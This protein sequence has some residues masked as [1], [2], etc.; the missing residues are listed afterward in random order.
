[1]KIMN[2][3][4][5]IHN[6]NM[7][8]FYV[9]IGSLGAC[10]GSFINM[11]A[12]RIPKILYFNWFVECYNFLEL[13]PKFSN[14]PKFNLNLF[15][16]RSHCPNCKKSI[17]FIDNI[18]IISYFLLRF[19]CRNCHQFI[20]IIYPLTEIVTTIASL[21]VVYKL[22][23]NPIVIFGLLLTW[24][25]ILQA[26]IDI[27]EYIIP[28]ELTLP[29]LWLGLIINN[30]KMFTQLE[31][32]IFGAIVGYLTFW[33]IYWVFKFMTGKDGIG[34]GD[35]KLVSMLGAWFGY[36]KLLL[37]ILI[38]SAIGSLVGVLLILFCQRSKEQPLSFG[39]YLAIA[40]WITMLW[41]NSIQH[42][43]WR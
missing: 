15:S 24:V 8:I 18:P 21:L 30:F 42:W 31:H 43:Y 14:I 40:G 41:G 28:D 27:K 32:A 7:S 13:K 39:P 35:F 36:E 26:V 37:I 6:V 22:G 9:F 12:Y 19:K 1:M 33:I 38:S 34:Y 2:I 5:F 3:V 20:P 23:I 25:L 17:A 16:P 10:I 29:M 11:A 4:D